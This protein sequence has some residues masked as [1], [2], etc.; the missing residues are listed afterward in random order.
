MS[1]RKQKIKRG[2]LNS[3]LIKNPIL[4]EAVGLSPVIAMTVSLKSAIILITASCIELLFIE[5]F[6]SLALKKV[7]RWIRMP[8][9]AMLGVLL[10]LPIFAF[11]NHFTPNEAQNVGIF[12]PLIAVNSLVALH[13]ERYAVKHSLK[14]T[15]IDAISACGGYA[16][17]ILLIGILR[18]IIGSGTLYSIDLH[19]PIHLSGMALPFGA[20]IMLGFLAAA[21]KA[22]LAKVVPDAHPERAFNMQE[23][24]QSHLDNFK[25]LLD[26]DFNPY[27]DEE[28]ETETVAR[29]P[30]KEKVKKEKPES[31]DSTDKKAKTKKEKPKKEKKD[32]KDKKAKKQKPQKAAKVKKQKDAPVQS[33]EQVATEEKHREK[34]L[35]RD[36]Y[37]LDFDEMLSDL[38]AYKQKYSSSDTESKETASDADSAEQQ[39]KGGDRE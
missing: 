19:L 11:F 36:S 6:A 4:F 21:A 20:F 5:L 39:E 15:F 18:E 29:K 1:N 26:T 34:R 17:V 2:I 28:D 33:P 14:S 27:A 38:D 16:L 12:L 25:A 24:S 23:I 37:L 10:N 13:C 32:K 31:K 35:E 30:R 9:Y 8:I 3:A 22:I 7:K